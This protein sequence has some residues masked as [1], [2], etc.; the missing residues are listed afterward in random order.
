M[1]E[2]IWYDD[3]QNFITIENY[4]VILPMVNMTFEEK[5]NAVVRFFMYLGIILALIKAQYKYLFLGIIAMVVSVLL[6]EFDKTQK[7]RAEKFLARNDMTVVDNKVCARS[8][9]DN[10]FMNPTTVDMTYN[11]NRPSAC[12]IDNPDVQAQIEKNFNARLFRN[13]GDIY[14]RESSQREFYTV[15]STTI[16]NDQTGFAEWLYGRGPTCK[17]GNSIQC[18]GN[19][20]YDNRFVS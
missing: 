8:T 14:D 2:R 17:E 11:P 13:V 20:Y 9:V 18:S 1:S 12:D 4:F 5:L 7:V 6:I 16:P 10:P 3:I 15:P 19:I